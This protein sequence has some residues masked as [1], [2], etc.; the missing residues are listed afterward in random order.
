MRFDGP[1]DLG[2]PL[3]PARRVVVIAQL[4]SGHGRGSEGAESRAGAL[5]PLGE[6]EVVVLMGGPREVVR[7]VPPVHE[8]VGRPLDVRVDLFQVGEPVR[9]VLDVSRMGDEGPDDERRIVDLPADVASDH[10]IGVVVHLPSVRRVVV[11]VLIVREAGTRPVYQTRLGFF[12]SLDLGIEPHTCVDVVVKPRD[13]Q[14]GVEKGAVAGPVLT[15]GWLA[16]N[17][18]DD[19]RCLPI[20][21]DSEVQ[22]RACREIDQQRVDT[23]SVGKS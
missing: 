20:H 3:L 7:V 22:Q 19:S 17:G 1:T 10:A 15:V 13:I 12:V 21:P 8:E 2:S 5:Q 4:T 16:R 23:R 14:G 9:V 6:G 11:I 18:G